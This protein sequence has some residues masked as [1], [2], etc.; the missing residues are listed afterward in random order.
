MRGPKPKYS[1]ELTIEEEQKLRK[2]ARS[3]TASHAKVMRSRILLAAYDHS[4]WSNQQ[5]AQKAGCTDRTVRKWRRRW[6][7][8]RSIDD[9]PRL[10]APRHFSP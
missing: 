10:G 3:H 5:I 4:E 6:A 8:T 2:L 9:L 7:K 1:I